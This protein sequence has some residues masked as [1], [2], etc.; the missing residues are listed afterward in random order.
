MYDLSDLTDDG[1]DDESN[2]CDSR[3]GATDPPKAGSGGAEALADVTGTAA[4][5]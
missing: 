3:R 2:P 4:A 5:V 1:S